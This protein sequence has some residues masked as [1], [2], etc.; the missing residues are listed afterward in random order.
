M[1]QKMR[2]LNRYRGFTL[3]ELLIALVVFA[4][5]SLMAYGGLDA[6][7]KVDETVRKHSADLKQLQRTWMMLGQDLTQLVGRSIRDDYGTQQPAL[8]A[9]EMGTHLLEF[10][11]GGWPNPTGLKRSQ[12][13]RVGYGVV[14]NKLIRYSWRMI[15]RAQGSE[16]DEYV[17]IGNVRGLNLRFLDSQGEWHQNWPPVGDARETLPIGAEI[18][19]ELEGGEEF[20]RLFR[21]TNYVW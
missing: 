3:I 18:V 17:L 6:V 15:D 14:N 5:L 11:R 16:P 10:T 9:S 20:R 13:R 12:L 21:T 1:G 7:L 2:R 8:I 19:L 4:T